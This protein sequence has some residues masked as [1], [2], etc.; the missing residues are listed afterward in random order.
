MM[1]IRPA[2]AAASSDIFATR[3]RR[4]ALTT[5]SRGARRLQA[6]TSFMHWHIH[7]RRRTRADDELACARTGL[8]DAAQVQDGRSW[9]S[10]CCVALDFRRG[11]EEMSVC[12]S[13]RSLRPVAC[14]VSVRR[15]DVAITFAERCAR[16]RFRFQRRQASTRAISR[17]SLCRALTASSQRAGV[18]SRYHQ[19]RNLGEECRRGLRQYWR[20]GPKKWA[21]SFAADVMLLEACASRLPLTTTRTSGVKYV[22]K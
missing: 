16:G 21:S 3:R 6:S 18:G 9:S 10:W 14:E 4:G 19:C 11:V 1:Y 17:R 20:H 13:S 2:A 8:A 12:I 15:D 22:F 5:S 7:H